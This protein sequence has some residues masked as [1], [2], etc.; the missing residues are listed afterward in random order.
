LVALAVGAKSVGLVF[1]KTISYVTS[2]FV[3]L[4]RDVFRAIRYSC[5]LLAGH[6]LRFICDRGFDDEKTFAFVVNLRQQFV[7]RLYHNRTL[8]VPR[9]TARV[10]R[11]LEEV[12]RQVTQP[13]RFDAWFKRRGRWCKCLVTL[14]YAQV[15]LPDHEHPYY[16]LVSHVHGIGQQWMLLTN[17]PITNAEQAREIWLNYRRRWRI[18]TTFRFLQKEG[19]RWDDFK[20]QDLEAIRRLIAMVLIAALF[21]LNIRLSLDETSLQILW[22]LG[23]KQG[24]KSERDGP[25]LALRGYQKLLGCLTTVAVLKRYGQLDSLLSILHDL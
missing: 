4:N 5:K 14:G 6:K 15:W 16:L 25:Y 11:S 7:I 12:V 9:G 3:S 21:L 24:L 23:G 10:Q 17:V 13:V 2:D 18:E 19:L 8:L 20:V 22:I 1:S